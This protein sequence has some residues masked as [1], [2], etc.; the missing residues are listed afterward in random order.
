MIIPQGF[1]V[2]TIERLVLVLLCMSTLPVCFAGEEWLR[3]FLLSN[4]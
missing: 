2:K 1:C 3:Q 4:T